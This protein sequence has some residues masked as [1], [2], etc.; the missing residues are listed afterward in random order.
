[1]MVS[2]ERAHSL[3]WRPAQIASPMVA[4]ASVATSRASGCDTQDSV[5]LASLDLTSSWQLLWRVWTFS[6]QRSWIL[7]ETCAMC[8]SHVRNVSREPADQHVDVL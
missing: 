8:K 6:H 4:T 1:V 5:T 7:C 3:V 2:F